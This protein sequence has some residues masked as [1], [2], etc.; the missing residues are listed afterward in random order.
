MSNFINQLIHS[1]PYLKR[2]DHPYTKFGTLRNLSK[3]SNSTLYDIHTGVDLLSSPDLDIVIPLGYNII[4]FG[5]FTGTQPLKWE[6]TDYII[7]SKSDYSDFYLIGD[8]K[9]HFLDKDLICLYEKPFLIKTTCLFDKNHKSLIYPEN[10][11][12]HIEQLTHLFKEPKDFFFEK[13]EDYQINYSK[14]ITYYKDPD[15]SEIV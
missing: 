6:E 14:L 5:T 13:E 1:N 12:V 7:V 8:I 11:M 9:I 15:F 4:S 10:S 3:V 2:S